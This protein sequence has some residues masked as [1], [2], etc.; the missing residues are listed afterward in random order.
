MRFFVSLFLSLA[1]L[2]MGCHSSKKAERKQKHKTERS[3]GKAVPKD[4]N[5]VIKTALTYEGTKY[6]YGG[7]TKKGIDC[8]G[9][10]YVSFKEAGI[11]L[12]RSSYEQSKSFKAIKLSEVQKGDL[13][14]FAT[15]NDKNKISHVGLVIEVSKAKD[16]YF[17]HAT[18]QRGVC[19]DWLSQEYYKERYVKAV[20]VL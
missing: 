17:I 11:E 14:F 9:L 6:K 20:R 2:L 3:T 19:K 13:V 4:V 7:I 12:P 10:M 8:S 18:T 15:G 5:K 1:L 16:I